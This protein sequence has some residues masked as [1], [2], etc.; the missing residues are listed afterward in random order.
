MNSSRMCCAYCTYCVPAPA[1]EACP[2]WPAWRTC[3]VAPGEWRALCPRPPSTRAPC[4]PGCPL[5]RPRRGPRP[6]HGRDTLGRTVEASCPSGL[7]G[8]RAFPC[9]LGGFLV[10]FL[11]CPL[12][13]WHNEACLTRCRATN[14]HHTEIHSS[15]SR[16]VF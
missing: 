13:P 6:P 3:A 7:V 12:T 10:L 8:V 16:T 5:G 15:V 9:C 14:S 2:H 1:P 11:H 4:I